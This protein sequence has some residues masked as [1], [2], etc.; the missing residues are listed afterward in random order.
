MSRRSLAG[1][2][3][4]QEAL[5]PKQLAEKLGVHP[6]LVYEMIGDGRITGFEVGKRR[7]FDYRQVVE[8]LSRQTPKQESSPAK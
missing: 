8:E 4:E 2:Q 6:N 1:S 5:T 7:R 3:L